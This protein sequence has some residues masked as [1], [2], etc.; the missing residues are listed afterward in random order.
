MADAGRIGK[1]CPFREQYVLKQFRLCRWARPSGQCANSAGQTKFGR[2]KD[3]FCRQQCLFGKNVP[4]EQ[5]KSTNQQVG[6]RSTMGDTVSL[7]MSQ[8]G[9]VH[10]MVPLTSISTGASRANSGFATPRHDARYQTASLGATLPR[11]YRVKK[12][13]L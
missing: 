9:A 4:R 10:H 6:P 11:D 8:R 2:A 13:Y 12:V 7:V 5:C 3:G 1:E